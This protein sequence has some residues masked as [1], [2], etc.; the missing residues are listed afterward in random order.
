M[1]KITK[2]LN[3]LIF[4][5]EKETEEINKQKIR[6]NEDP[7]LGESFYTFHLRVLRDL[8]DERNKEIQEV[9]N[10]YRT[11]ELETI[12]VSSTVV[13]DILE[14]LRKIQNL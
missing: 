10:K 14:E 6:D 2:L 11:V 9:I 8:V 7:L 3:D 1:S 12:S 5:S 13:T 4:L